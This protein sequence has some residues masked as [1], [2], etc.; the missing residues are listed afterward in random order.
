VLFGFWGLPFSFLVFFFFF[1]FRSVLLSVE[2][3]P[4]VRLYIHVRY[5]SGPIASSAPTSLTALCI[6]TGLTPSDRSPC[7]SSASAL[8]SG[9]PFWDRA[10]VQRK[11]FCELVCCLFGGVLDAYPATIAA[12]TMSRGKLWCVIS[13]WFAVG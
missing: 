8:F 5:S 9:A 2:A 10:S 7:G 1:F 4:H 3:R 12:G 11:L 13:R 6:H